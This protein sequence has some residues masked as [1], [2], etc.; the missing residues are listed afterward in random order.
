MVKMAPRLTFGT[1][2]AEWQERINVTR[3]R[4]ERQEKARREM[5]KQGIPA[6]LATR[7][8][9][10]RYL[11]GVKGP[12][13]LSQLWYV[14]FFAEH[15]PVV[16][17]H[18]GWFHNY[19]PEAPWIKHWRL[20]RNWVNRGPGP[21]ATAAEAKLFAD[22]VHAEL[23]ERGLQGE[24]LA[25]IGF[26][27]PAQRALVDKG[28]KTQDGWPLMLDITRTKTVDEINC[29]K[30]AYAITDAA[31]ARVW[32]LARPGMDENELA[33][34]AMGAALRAGAEAVPRGSMHT[35]P[36]TF[37]RGIDHTHR[38]VSYGD[39]LY[40]AFCGVSFLGYN[41][42]YY[43]TFSV[44]KPPEPRVQ[45]WYKKLIDRMDRIIDQ[46]KP[47]NTTADAARLFEP[48]SRWGYGDEAEVLTVEIGHGIGM[49]HY[50]YPIINRQWSL[51]HPMPFE[52]GMVLA[53]ESLE[54]EPGLGGVR[55][56]D[57]IVV[58]EDGCELIDHWPRNEILVAPR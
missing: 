21:E 49:Y 27:A 33:H 2:I 58:T 56:E 43:R 30:M 38:L 1:Q 40:A 47:G 39:L 31:W 24:P 28:L 50:G 11:S 57:A 20:A 15:D 18:A 19:P 25:V 32:E 36:E 41:T 51:D 16:F 13:W 9:N 3:L 10:A 42:C 17:H 48:A 54:G 52:P 44:G 29:L 23:A 14:L 6:I 5:R 7:P 26:D 34:E 35:G 45:D 8:E 53:L 12:E 46:I 37:E 55:I 4:E 22:G